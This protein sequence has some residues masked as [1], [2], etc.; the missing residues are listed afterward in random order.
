[1][2]NAA[3]LW[4]AISPQKFFLPHS[5]FYREKNQYY[6]AIFAEMLRYRTIFDLKQ[7]MGGQK[8]LLVIVAIGKC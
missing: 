5:L 6:F 1:L 7:I 8:I 4:H 3:A 2:T